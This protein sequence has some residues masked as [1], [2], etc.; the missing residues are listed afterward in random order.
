MLG[1]SPVMKLVNVPVPVPL[2]VQLGSVTSG[3][4]DVP[5]Q[6]PRSVTDTPPSEVT[7]PPLV[8]VVLVSEETAEVITVGRAAAESVVKVTSL[9]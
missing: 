1:D 5:Q 8:A 2:W 7:V 4:S 6:T 9:P 3:L